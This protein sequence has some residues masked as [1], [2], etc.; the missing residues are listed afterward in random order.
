MLHGQRRRPEARAKR[1]STKKVP[2]LAARQLTDLRRLTPDQMY[3][4]PVRATTSEQV[5]PDR[6]L[7]ATTAKGTSTEYHG[8]LSS[9]ELN[10]SVGA[11]KRALR[12]WGG[13][14]RV[15][16]QYAILA[17]RSQP[18]GNFTSGVRV[19]DLFDEWHA[20]YGTK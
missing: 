1:F 12:T 8:C 13:R 7:F 19:A 14:S 6:F 16:R 9:K 11:L 20:K 3:Q 10:V 4:T 15:Q 18:V 5:F 17:F 2:E